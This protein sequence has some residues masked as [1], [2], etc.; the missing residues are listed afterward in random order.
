MLWLLGWEGF[1]VRKGKPWAAWSQF[2]C[3]RSE[4]QTG[5]CSGWT[6][7]PD[8]MWQV[9]VTTAALYNSY[10]WYPLSFSMHRCCFLSSRHHT[11]VLGS[12]GQ[13]WSFGNG[14]K[15]QIGT[16][17]TENSL[18]PCLVQFPWTA[19]RAVAIPN[20]MKVCSGGVF[21]LILTVQ[22]CQMSQR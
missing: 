13:L 3:Q 7:L 10:V 14:V 16:G 21:D 2:L 22:V 4:T 8:C 20:G 15:G 9:K 12:S 19:D 17:R 11:L 1:H 5:W 18:T 6:C